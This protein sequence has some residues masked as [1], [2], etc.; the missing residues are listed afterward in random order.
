[1]RNLFFAGQINGTTGYEEA[2]AQGF[3]AGINAAASARGEAPFLIDRSQAYI[4][5]LIDDLVTR[6]VDEPYRMFTSRAEYRLMLRHDNADLRLT[7]R[8]RTVGLVDDVKVGAGSKAPKC[9][10]E[11]ARPPRG[12]PSRGCVPL[13]GP[14]RPDVE[15]SD[16]LALDLSLSEAGFDLAVVEQ[17]TVDAKYAGYIGRQSAQVER[18]RRLEEKR[19]PADIDYRTIRQLRAEA[20]EKLERVRPHSLGQAGRIS[21][22]SPSDIA[23]LLIHLKRREGELPAQPLAAPPSQIP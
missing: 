8:G 16:V 14:G 19:I 10:R 15:W 7:E 12:H 17:V 6:G 4:G 13:S 11:A 20:R 18:F 3:V 22:I 21:G 9:D 1:M 23:T 5:V 2:A